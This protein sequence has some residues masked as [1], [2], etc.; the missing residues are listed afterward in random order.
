MIV[1]GYRFYP[2]VKLRGDK[3]KKDGKQYIGA[4]VFPMASGREGGKGDAT[5][6]YVAAIE[7]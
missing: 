7:Q 5:G 1:N 6:D 2:L 3:R 4:V